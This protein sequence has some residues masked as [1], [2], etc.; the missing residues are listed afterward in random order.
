MK[1][2]D[3]KQSTIS[4]Q[5]DGFADPLD[6]LQVGNLYPVS[7]E[8]E[9]L[10][11]VIF[12]AQRGKYLDEIEAYF[13]YHP[14]LKDVDI[15]FFNELDIGMARSG[16]FNTA[17]ELAQRLKMNYLFGAEFLELTKGEENERTIPGENN[18]ALHGNAILSR[19]DLYEPYLL[20]LLVEYD[21][22]EDYQKRLG[23]RIAL[24]AKVKVKEKELGLVCT[25]L[26]NKTSPEGRARQMEQI[27]HHVKERFGSLPV[28]IGGDINTNTIDE[29]DQEQ[30]PKAL[31]LLS[32]ESNRRTH[33]EKYESLFAILE[34]SG[35]DYKE[36]NLPG[37]ITC[38]G[39]QEKGNTLE[40]NLDWIFTKGLRS[41]SP[42][43]IPTIFYED[44]FP[45][46]PN[47]ERSEGIEISDHNV[48][49]V[50]VEFS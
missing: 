27:L 47:M 40:L 44:K 24:F 48:I 17:R 16:N 11:L 31:T 25:H 33:P 23:S 20:R 37:K 15:I 10:K 32:K 7:L 2:I 1:R 41:S 42:A 35:F 50:E 4:K 39:H 9:R 3:Q 43:V 8:K 21:W 29:R 28:V 46:L 5:N 12:N 38:R 19:F 49:S 22:Y 34:E 18:E 30:V 14:I 6:E 26:E 36:A 45:D 13:T